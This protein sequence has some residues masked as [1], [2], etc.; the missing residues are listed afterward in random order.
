MREIIRDH[1]KWRRQIITLAKADLKK[2]YSGSV[3]GWAWALIRPAFVIFVYWFAFSMGLRDRAGID[4][5][6][7]FLWLLAGII[8]WFYIQQMFNQGPRVMRQYNHLVTKMK[9]PI[10]TIPTFVGISHLVV[11]VI[12]LAAVILIF[13]FS[14]MPPTIYYLQLPFYMILMFVFCVL[15]TLFSS[16]LGAISMDF[17]NLVRSV[18][19]ALFWLS[20]ILFDVHSIKVP[21]AQMIFRIN[22]ITYT[23][24]GY[25][26]CFIYQ[27][28][29][30]EDP[31][32]LLIYL[33][34]MA[35]MFLAAMW[36]YRR[37]RKEIPDV[38]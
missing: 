26:N 32:S 33:A 37:L 7:F 6:P 3:L 10:S 1:I 5:F 12:L 9:F 4:G 27:R 23:V 28:W 18:S 29:F 34:E 14:G 30:W 17:I 11:H 19:V 13:L 25:R 20:G 21:L 35:V 24:E 38:L 16:L 22:P 31:Q 2:Q 36:V 15:W 8:S